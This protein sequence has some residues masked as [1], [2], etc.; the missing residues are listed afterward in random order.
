MKK[1]FH[2]LTNDLTNRGINAEYNFKINGS[3]SS[4][5]P[6]HHV[7]LCNFKKHVT[8]LKDISSGALQL[9]VTFTARLLFVFVFINV[10]CLTIFL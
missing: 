4:L 3:N 7:C 5:S 6:L 8:I 2:L 10:C 1:V 9:P